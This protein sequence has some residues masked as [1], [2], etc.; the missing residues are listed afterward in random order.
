[1]KKTIADR[2]SIDGKLYR[3]I[4]GMSGQMIL[5]SVLILLF[6]VIYG[7]QYSAVS[8]NITDA[9]GFN[10]NFKNDVDL[11]MYSFVSGSS[12]E[13]PYEEIETAQRL[14]EKL[15][16][17][18]TN[19][20]SRKAINNVLHLCNSLERSVTEIRDTEGYDRRIEQLETNIYVITDLIEEHIYTYLFHEAGEMAKLHRR[21]ENWIVLEVI[22]VALVVALA[23]RRALSRSLAI[24]RSITDPI[25][26]LCERVEE[27]G[28]GNLT[29]KA[30]VEAEDR[31]LQT[32]SA[33]MEGMAGRLQQQ[34]ELNRLEQEK[35]RGIELSL[36]QAQINPHFLYNTLDAIV[37]LIETGRNDEAEQMVTNLSTYFRSFLSNGKEIITLSEE[38]QH[39]RS[40][41]MIQQV[42]YRDV[43][44]YEIDIDP[45]LEEILIPKMTLQP[46]V[47]NAIY[48]GIKPKRGQGTIRVEGTREDGIAVLRVSDTGVGMTEEALE[49]L[50][51]Q[52]EEED[53]NSFGLMAANKRLKLMYGD[54]CSFQIESEAGKGT[55]ITIRIPMAAK[56]IKNV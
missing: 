17:N 53:E 25:D 10:Q 27:I 1:M 48:H 8:S 5:I 19:S 18:T 33:G 44:N 21:L 23:I 46:L 31:K 47:E 12:D 28:A 55:V 3:L 2:S 52:V 11:K 51:K 30:P 9:S 40:Y 14:A 39:I 37:W 24:S 35:L 54:A 32:L 22:A 36:I 38:E 15:L 49:Q 16:K 29:E 41:L 13:L 50:R 26:R 4:A 56:E 43:L 42:R 34:I 6:L 20:D 7:L 45:E